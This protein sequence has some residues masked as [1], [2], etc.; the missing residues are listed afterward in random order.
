LQSFNYISG[1]EYKHVTKA[2][3][4]FSHTC[5][6]KYARIHI[7][8]ALRCNIQ[9]NYCERGLNAYMKRPGFAS[10]VLTPVEALKAVE[11]AVKDHHELTVVG[12][13]GPGDALANEDTFTALELIHAKYPGLLKCVATNGLELPT[14]ANRLLDC[15]V[16]AV[17]VTVNAVDPFIASQIYEYTTF[18]SETCSGIKA[19]QTLISNQ[20]KGIELSSRLGLCVK[21]NTV[22]IPKVN[23]WHVTEVAKTVAQRGAFIMNIIPLIPGHKFNHLTPPTYEE[24]KN[25]RKLCSKYI[26]Q[27][28]DCKLCRADACGI[29][30]L[31]VNFKDQM[32][33][34]SA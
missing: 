24:I 26:I 31:E 18:K 19:A 33:C 12:V 32:Q 14:N 17:T 9:C 2:H 20:F 23:D 21:V 10:K 27:F 15:G 16:K 5:H 3:P 4:C 8:V 25:A 22:L 7:P 6:A 13:A 29:P 1:E 11:K 34:C 30:G 28:K